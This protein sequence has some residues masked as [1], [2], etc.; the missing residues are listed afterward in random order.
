MDDSGHHRDMEQAMN[1][2]AALADERDL[3]Q[4][5]MCQW[6]QGGFK[7]IDSVEHSGMRIETWFFEHG[8]RQTKDI[9]LML[10]RGPGLAMHCMWA[11]QWLTEAARSQRDNGYVRVADAILRHRDKVSRSGRGEF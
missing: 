2:A 8:H 9:V 4:S 5:A 11:N 3:W 7:L 1:S 6:L 10:S